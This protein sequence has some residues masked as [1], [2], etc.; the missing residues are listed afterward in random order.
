MSETTLLEKINKYTLTCEIR[1]IFYPTSIENNKGLIFD[2]MRRLCQTQINLV[3]INFPLGN[4][5]L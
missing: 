2:K 3:S 4:P 1:V 5:W